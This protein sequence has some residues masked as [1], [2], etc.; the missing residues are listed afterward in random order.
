M[1]RIKSAP[2][3]IAE[4]VNNKRKIISQNL[5]M[6]ILPLTKVNKV[7]KKA[8]LNIPKKYIELGVIS[9]ITEYI[10]DPQI[11][12]IDQSPIYLLDILNKNL[13]N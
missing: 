8:E 13:K 4:M 3:N 5:Q 2:G 9:T 1:K 7:E 6:N 12:S 11:L 10:S